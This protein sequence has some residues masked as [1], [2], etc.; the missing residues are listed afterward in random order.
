MFDCRNPTPE[1]S[2]LPKWDK[3]EGFPINYYRIG[4]FHFEDK[5][6]FG[7]ETGGLFE[8]RAEFWREIRTS[9]KNETFANLKASGSYNF[10]STTI[11]TIFICTHLLFALLPVH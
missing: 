4:N 8:N 3:V 2:Y 7:M 6:M 10:D 5:P 9:Y 11:Y 1:L